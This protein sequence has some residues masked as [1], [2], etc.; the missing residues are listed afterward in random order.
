MLS[1]VSSSEIF[2]QKIVCCYSVLQK[3]VKPHNLGK[4]TKNITI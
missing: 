2:Q 3:F 4:I 1:A